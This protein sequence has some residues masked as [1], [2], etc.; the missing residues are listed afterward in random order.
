MATLYV[1]ENEYWQV[2][3]LPETGGAVAFARLRA[4]DG[5]VDFMRP[6]AEADYDNVR[7]CASFPLVPWSNRIKNATFAFDGVSYP[8]T[9]NSAD[10][11]AIHGVGRYHA[12][13]VQ[14]ATS[15]QVVMALDSR[16]LDAPNFPFAFAAYQ[17]YRLEGTR[18]VIDLGVG[19]E[20]DHPFP[21]GFGHHPYFQRTLFG[22]Q[23]TIALELPYTAQF[24]LTDN[25][26][27]AAPTPIKPAFDF[28]A[29]RP[30]DDVQIDACLTGRVPGQPI[31]FV[32]TESGAEIR[33]DSDPIFGC[34]ILYSPVGKP[35]FAVEPVTNTNDGFNLYAQGV[36][37]T[38]VF[39]LE[40]GEGE[41]GSMWFEV[42]V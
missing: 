33:L 15:E 22:P 1:L 17:T 32:Y 4:G 12:W 21:A 39:V 23:D 37:E 2:G 25:L 6:T 30:L 26:A 14:S 5:W 7:M 18:F 28:R 3:V 35:Y 27:T 24:D 36:P 13:E 20:A 31:R 19:N 16:T 10:G 8:L 41:Q 29:L 40:P 9:A 11:N 42:Q 38:G 34:N